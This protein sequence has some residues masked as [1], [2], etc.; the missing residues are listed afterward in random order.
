MQRE[1]RT[2]LLCGLILSVPLAIACGTTSLPAAETEQAVFVENGQAKDVIVVGKKWTP[3]DGYLECEGIDNYL[4][5]GKGLGTGDCRVKVRLAL[6]NVARSA[7]SFEIFASHFGFDGGPGG[8][9]VS[10]PVFGKL[11]FIGQF[12]DYLSE[13]KPFELEVIR[14]AGQLTFLIDGKEAYKHTDKRES[15]GAFALRPWRATMR[16]YGFSASG[17]LEKAVIPASIKTPDYTPF[18][19]PTI[20]EKAK[21]LP[22]K[23]RLLPP[24]PGNSRNSEGDFVQLNDGR[25]LLAYAHYFDKGGDVSPAH[26]A[27]RFSSDGGKTWTHQ[28][29]DIVSRVGDDSIRSVSLLRLA[30]GRIALFYLQC[31][32]WPEDERPFMRI[33]ADEAKTWSEPVKIIPDEDSGYY[34]TNN[35]RVVQLKSG[36][37]LLPTSLHH[38]PP[39]KQFTGFGRIMTYISDDAGRSWRRSKTVRTGERPDGKRIYLQEPGIIELKDGRLMMFCRTNLGCQYISYSADAGESWSQFDSSDIIS[40]RSPASIERIPKTG[41]LLMVWN[42]HQNVAPVYR[43]KRS[44]LNVAISRDEGRTWEKIKTLQDDPGGHYCYTAIHFVGDH[45]LLAYCAGQRRSG[46]LNLTQITRFSLDWLYAQ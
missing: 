10:G 35:D 20:D 26:V 8:M 4:F 17:R 36:R 46:G 23:N 9:F 43:G 40:P 2:A 19:I 16:V 32:N 18:P 34:V 27:G 7:A 25:I 31:M 30:D 6:L 38:D 1:K 5:A 28:D 44:P 29:V 41:D 14:K 13:G 21:G 42:N 22:Q 15:F 45:V 12:S 33:S 11:L 37:L 39:A 3:G 24:G